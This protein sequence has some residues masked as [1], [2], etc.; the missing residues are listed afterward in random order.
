MKIEQKYNKLHQP[1]F[2][3][4]SE[5][6]S[7]IPHFGVTTFVNHL[8]VSELIGEEDKEA[9]NYLT[10]VEVTE[11]EDIKLGYRIDF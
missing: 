7:Q 8:Q 3:K 9:L 10:R 2:H 1:F 11:F 4:K 5:L 6:I